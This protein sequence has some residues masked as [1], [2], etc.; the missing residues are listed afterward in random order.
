MT[1]V[2]EVKA[3][4]D[5]KLTNAAYARKYEI[6]KRQASKIMSL[7]REAWK[8]ARERAQKLD[9]PMASHLGKGFSSKGPGLPGNPT[10]T[11]RLI[12]KTRKAR[13]A[14]PRMRKRR[15]RSGGD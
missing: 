8:A 7:P 14:G 13:E 5:S 12:G 9:Y 15:G 6:T 2:K 11:T 4:D 3:Q 10:D 1:E